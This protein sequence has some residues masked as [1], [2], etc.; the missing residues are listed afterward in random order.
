MVMRNIRVSTFPVIATLLLWAMAIFAHPATLTVTNTND[1]GPGSLRQALANANNGDV[2]TFA[3][4]GTIVLTTGELLVHKS[5]IISGPGAANLTVDGNA[6]SRA[7]H[8]LPNLNVSITGLTITN[9]VAAGNPTRGGGIYNDHA[10]LTL[11]DCTI[12]GNRAGSGGGVYNDNSSSGHGS[13]TISGSSLSGNTARFGGAIYNDGFD[14]G[15]AGLTITNS[16]FTGNSADFGGCI[17]NDSFAGSASFALRDTAFAG[18]AA[19]ASGGCIYNDVVKGYGTQTLTNSSLRDNSAADRGGSIYS[20]H[21]QSFTLT[22]CTISNNSAQNRGGG[23]YNDGSQQG[24]AWLTINSSTL[25]GNSATTGGGIFNDGEQQGDTQLQITNSTISDN[26][27]SYGGGLASDG[28]Y[29]FYVAVQINNST[30]SGNSATNSGGGIYVT[31]EGSQQVIV[32][33]ANTILKAGAVGNN[34]FNDSGT[35]SSFGYNLSNDSCDGLLTGPGDQTNTEPML[36]P[37]QDNGGP[38]PTHA[39]LPGSPAIDTGDPALDPPSVYDQRGPGFSRV[40]NGRIDIGS[41]E[42][43]VRTPAPRPVPVP[44]PRPTPR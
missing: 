17:Y 5:T 44:R 31:G 38:T 25:N 22:N 28:Y 42:V 8:I 36:G 30:F 37:L 13:I 21:A 41:F 43:Q 6:A 11:N 23:V 33:L 2:I 19:H 7:F 27:A 15:D 9:G 10:A 32:N 12:S 40:V 20:H 39:L 24:A 29:G 26:T 16:T 4:T 14:T 18:N 3:V 1:A 34:I 35:V